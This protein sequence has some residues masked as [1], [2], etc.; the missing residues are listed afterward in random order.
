VAAEVVLVA[1]LLVVQA[2]Q[3]GVV[4]AAAVLMSQLRLRQTLAAEVVAEN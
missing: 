1:P 4:L 3:A 2:E